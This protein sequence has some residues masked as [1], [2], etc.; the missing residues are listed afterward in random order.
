MPVLP[1]PASSMCPASKLK[2]LIPGKRRMLADMGS[3]VNS[4]GVNAAREFD[5]QSRRRRHI[6][7]VMDLE[8]LPCVNGVGSG[9]AM[10]Q[11]MGASTIACNCHHPN[12][13]PTA[14]VDAFIGDI[15]E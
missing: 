14:K 2:T 3:N 15:A 1:Q 5:Y 11:T 13:P 6:P 12:K 8:R 4:I 10:R 7:K 9:A